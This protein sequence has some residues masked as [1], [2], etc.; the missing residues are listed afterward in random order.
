LHDVSTSSSQRFL[1]SEKDCV[2]L[3]KQAI[4]AL[5]FT[6]FSKHY[7]HLQNLFST[8]SLLSEPPCR[9]SFI[10]V[11]IDMTRSSKPSTV[12]VTGLAHEYPQ[13][14]VKQEQFQE[15]IET[16]YPEHSNAKG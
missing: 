12:Y 4:F 6:P 13:F 14:S 7:L 8:S 15:L 16:L 11:E 10:L 9:S 3:G 1:L 2:E 5:V